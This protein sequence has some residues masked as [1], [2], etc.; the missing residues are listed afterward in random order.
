MFFVFFS[1]AT[2]RIEGRFLSKQISRLDS[3]EG[4]DF[5]P[6]AREINK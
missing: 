2:M 6:N 4:D 5:D 1:G 3:N